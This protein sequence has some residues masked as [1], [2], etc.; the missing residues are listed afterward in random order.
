MGGEGPAP[1]RREGSVERPRTPAPAA[2][3]G[4]PSDPL[5]EIDPVLYEE[6]RAIAG[7]ALRGE[8][9]GERHGTTSLVHEVWLRIARSA[10]PPTDGRPH[11]LALASLVA[12]RALV[13]AARTRRAAKRGGDRPHAGIEASSTVPPAS[14]VS[15]ETPDEILAIDELL[16][17]LAK[18]HPRQAKALEMRVFGDVSPTMIGEALGISPTQAKRDSA[19]GRAWLV[20]RLRG[21]PRRATQST[22][23]S[24]SCEHAADA[25]SR[26]TMPGT[27]PF[28]LPAEDR[29]G[30]PDSDRQT[31]DVGHAPDL[32]SA[33][34][35]PP[36]SFVRGPRK[37]QP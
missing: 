36:A 14:A 16:E 32:R 4:C 10:S 3:D 22:T 30:A 2:P 28:G 1:T 24:P 29:H 17:A 35:A 12:R 13:D 6:L 26:V 8:R 7:R 37:Q 18:A 9:R 5:R 11:L 25:A 21:G 27:Q 20:D 34:D 23:G 15:L 31:P 19:F 33:P